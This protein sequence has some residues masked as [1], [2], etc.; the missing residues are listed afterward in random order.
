MPSIIKRN[1][2]PTSRTPKHTSPFS[3]TYTFL[4]ITHSVCTYSANMEETDSRCFAAYIIEVPGMPLASGPAV[5]ASSGQ[6]LRQLSA[7][8]RQMNKTTVLMR[9]AMMNNS[10]RKEKERLLFYFLSCMIWDVLSARMLF[11]R[12][13][14]C[15]TMRYFLF[16]LSFKEWG[17]EVGQNVG[18]C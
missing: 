18:R 10:I 14:N 9:L 3:L 11:R 5:S 6:L 16:T 7:K 8:L 12:N 15:Y 17:Q 1:K 2:T 4:K 13:I